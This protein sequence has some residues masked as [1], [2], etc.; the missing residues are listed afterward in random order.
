MTTGLLA[1]SFALGLRHGFDWDHIAAIADLNST[2]DERRRG[3]ALS[4]YYALGHAVVH[5]STSG[6]VGSSEP[7]WSGS[8]SPCC[9]T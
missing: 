5:R 6:W 3:F 7:H 4:L 1:T 2:A 8:A 9:G